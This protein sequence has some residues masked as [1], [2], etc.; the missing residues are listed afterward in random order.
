MRGFVTLAVG[1]EKYYKLATNLLNSY[2]YNTKNFMPFAIIADRC[3]EY[4]EK[5][6]KVVLLERATYSYMDKLEMLNHPP[7]DENIFIDADCLAYG[8]IN[9]FWRYFPESGGGYLA[10]ERLYI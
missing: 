2:K 9:E 6:D 10:L 8:D 5:F 4:T 3:N 1:D 7:Y